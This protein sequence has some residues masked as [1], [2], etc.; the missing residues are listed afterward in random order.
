MRGIIAKFCLRQECHSITM[1]SCN[2]IFQIHV[3]DCIDPFGLTI[4]LRME[5]GDKD[6]LFVSHPHKV[7][8]KC[9]LELNISI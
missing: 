4:I 9:T 3:E 7:L 2:V 6:E 5:G 8:S 1:T